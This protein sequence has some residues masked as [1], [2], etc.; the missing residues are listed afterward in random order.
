MNRVL[1]VD[2]GEK[3]IGIAVSDLTGTIA[4]PLSIL[5]HRS[6]HEDAVQIAILAAE[7]QAGAIVIGQS[8]EED[9]SLKPIG[10]HA[11]KLAD[12]IRTVTD[13]PVIMWD[14]YGSTIKARR[15]RIEMG[16]KRSKRS[17]HLDDLAATIILQSFLDAREKRAEE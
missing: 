14:E 5:T 17:G 12:E 4:N 6:R 9:D 1:A 15:A 13:L 8:L 7:N 2:P 11:Q 16:V 10:R 3:R